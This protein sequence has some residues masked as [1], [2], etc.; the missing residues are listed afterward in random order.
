MIAR[1]YPS[2]GATRSFSRFDTPASIE[3]I[4]GEG[5]RSERNLYRTV[6]AW[7]AP[8]QLRDV[9][10]SVWARCCNGWRVDGIYL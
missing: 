4:A 5:Q 3:E 9:F 6:A 10:L 7:T 8:G 1:L 2:Y